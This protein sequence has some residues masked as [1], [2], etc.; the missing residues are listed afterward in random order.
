MPQVMPYQAPA[1]DDGLAKIGEAMKFL[2]ISRSSVYS[3]MD[4]GALPYVKIGASRRLEWRELRR[5]VERSRV[6]TAG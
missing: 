5:L 3:L 1:R 2:G 6:G 4:S